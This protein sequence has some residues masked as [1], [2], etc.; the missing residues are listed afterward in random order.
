MHSAGAAASAAAAAATAGFDTRGKDGASVPAA[1]TVTPVS[2]FALDAASHPRLVYSKYMAKMPKVDASHCVVLHGDGA[3]ILPDPDDSRRFKV[4]RFSVRADTDEDAAAWVAALHDAVQL[5]MLDSGASVDSAGLDAMFAGYY[6]SSTHAAATTACG[7]Q[8][9]ATLGASNHGGGGGSSAASSGSGYSSGGR[10][11]LGPKR[12][13]GV[14]PVGGE[15]ASQMAATARAAAAAHALRA[16]AC[17]DW[18]QLGRTA[19]DDKP[20]AIAD[21]ARRPSERT[22]VLATV[23]L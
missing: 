22:T 13:F 7:S 21:A 4:G 11:T 15:G 10:H 14:L 23:Y 12:S 2:A 18:A 17:D 6:G 8:F 16:E 1:S 9:T 5:D 3:L 19:A 20:A